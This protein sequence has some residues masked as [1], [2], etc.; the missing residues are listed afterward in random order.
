MTRTPKLS[1]ALMSLLL[2]ACPLTGCS[3]GPEGGD[4]KTQT[5]P[6][7][8]LY[9]GSLD[10]ATED[11]GQ[12]GAATC[13][14]VSCDD[15][16]PCTDDLCTDEKCTHQN[17][18]AT[19]DDGNACT[20]GDRCGGG[21]CKAGP[22][23]L[24]VDGGPTDTK[25]PDTFT[26]PTCAGIK[27]GDL[28]ITE[29]LYDP[30]GTKEAKIDDD[31]GEWFEVYNTTD[32][33][34]DISGLLL[35][36][37]KKDKWW[38]ASTAKPIAAKSHYV[39]GK[40]ADTATNGGVT[41]DFEYGKSFNLTN[42]EDVVRLT[43]G[44]T[45][46]DEVHYD[47]KGGWPNLSGT[48]LALSPTATTSDKNDIATNWCP[49]T[50]KLAS[51]DKGTPGKENSICADNDQDDD[52][53]EDKEDN[54]PNTPNPKQFDSNSDGQGD[55]CEPGY[56]AGCG[57]F[58]LD[59]TKEACDDGNG[60]SGDGCSFFCQKET[61]IPA[62]SLIIT[63]F[64]SN[65][66]AVP[67][68]TGEWVEIRNI[69]DK[70][71]ELNGLALHVGVTKTF[72]SVVESPTKLIVK[73]GAEFVLGVS[74]DPKANGGAP[75]G[76]VLVAKNVNLANSKG[77]IALYAGATLLDEVKY[78]AG[79]VLKT[80]KSTS[81]DI[82]IKD[83]TKNDD[84]AAWCAG[85]LPYGAGDFGTPGQPNHP[86]SLVEDADKDGIPDSLDSCPK[87]KDASHADTDKDG[88]GD[89][90]DNCPALDNKDQKDSNKDG[91]GDACES[92]YCGNGILEKGEVCDD[93]NGL[94][95]DGC[96]VK[97]ALETALVEGD[98]VI[99]EFHAN[100][101]AVS[102]KSGEWVELYNP[103]TLD[104]ALDGLELVLN[105]KS[106][107]IVG[108]KQPLVIKSGAYVVLAASASVT[109]N[110]NVPFDYVYAGI[111]LSNASGSVTLRW[112]AAVI[113]EIAYSSGAA[114]WPA[115]K[116][117]A[118]ISMSGELT[119]TNSNH[120]GASWCNAM[121]PYGAGD[122]GTPGKVNPP[123]PK[124]ADK[125]AVPDS[126][127]NC[128]AKANAS[129]GDSD[130]D[131]VGNA[132]DN[133]PASAN[134]DQADKN[135]N[136]KGDVCDKLPPTV[137]GNGKLEG[138]EN[139]DDGNKKG[140]DGC[141][142]VCRKE[143]KA[144]APGALVVTEFLASAATA[145][146]SAGE[147]IELY[148][149]TT[150]DIDIEGFILADNSKGHHVIANGG[151]GVVVKKG[152]Y[153]LLGRSA[154]LTENTG[155]NPDYV[156]S[157]FTL[158]N[159]TDSVKLLNPDLTTVIDMAQ[160]GDG[161]GGWPQT[162]SGATLQ[163]DA[164]VYL[165]S[166]PTPVEIANDHGPN[167]CIGWDVYGDG[168]K[169]T[170]GK[171][172]RPCDKDSDGDGVVD[173]KDNCP[174]VKNADQKDDNKNGKGDVCDAPPGDIK[175]GQLVI[176]EY[177][178]RSQSGSDSGE[179]FELHNPTKAAIDLRGV[180]VFVK[181][182]KKD[183]LAGAGPIVI[184]A[185]GYFVLGKTLDKSKNNDAPVQYAVKGLALS[186]SGSTLE[187]KFLGVMIDELKFG[188][189]LPWPSITLATSAQLTA[190][191]LT[192]KDNDTPANWCLSKSLYGAKGLK[193]TP[194]KPNMACVAD[195]P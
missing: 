100:P 135:Q 130:K 116:D 15:K 121:Q 193:G 66:S 55:K 164:G 87:G 180:E 96:S 51:E 184:P 99:T 104:H 134:K 132:C 75:I 133:C 177:M 39:F 67:D 86:C 192:E 178:A 190:T 57:D 58:K 59:A 3:D 119:A 114:G 62:G 115:F 147:W 194:G 171:P 173:G 195:P 6:D 155:I 33:E 162:P 91:V 32:A 102:D 23:D 19:C 137:C 70:D 183:T 16:N 63:E 44:D 150:V 189:G 73:A 143:P 145:T 36:D 118:A 111:G 38:V 168:S 151:E 18:K 175:P 181:G 4:G 79:W 82:A 139:C 7:V 176:S 161:K 141:S 105:K 17:N 8:A 35:T 14:G 30:F 77:T 159:T 185:G 50:D 182:G 124:D 157:G 144:L 138:V 172:N 53:V 128:P 107:V 98:V 165:A 31:K 41:V 125:D 71:V 103:T 64:M 101:K 170:P 47:E 191:K 49:A 68:A 65:P 2:A 148:N 167:W 154:S 85:K 140:A 110:G 27:A 26:S 156:Y 126:V 78:S 5:I 129:Q 127:D 48:A 34:I 174:M 80:G 93:G 52:G 74:G 112:N 43:C 21:S 97:C 72:A 88:L 24:C 158:N 142:S 106:H 56:I 123:C 136:G 25:E 94:P 1:A 186:N 12:G 131:G 109:D 83:A 45:M 9:G 187:L 152:G 92:V 76:N 188:K 42:T 95:G 179:W 120:L 160:Y 69:S 40:N 20:S 22:K 29:I 13:G 61:P 54:C 81:L 153:V 122:L 37:D 117:G 11:A 84:S 108:K 169:G 146:D 60:K 113:D 163:L 46:V 149:P 166:S 10:G 90:C 89:V 28:V